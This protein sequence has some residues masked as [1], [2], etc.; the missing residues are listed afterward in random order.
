M[1]I[2]TVPCVVRDYN[3]SNDTCSVELQGVGVIETWIDGMA[4][5]PSISRAKLASGVAGV[6]TMSDVHRLCGAVLTSIT[7][8]PATTPRPATVVIPISSD[9]QYGQIGPGGCRSAPHPP[10]FWN[11]KTPS[12][13]AFQKNSFS[14]VTKGNGLAMAY[15]KL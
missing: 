13:P 6:V 8:N 14:G 3:A 2:V 4:I 7:V 15:L 12:A 5:D 9:R 1:T 10:H 11:F